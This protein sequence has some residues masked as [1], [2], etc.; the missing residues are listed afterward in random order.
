MDRSLAPSLSN[1]FLS[2]DNSRDSILR[3]LDFSQCDFG[4]SRAINIL[5][6]SNIS[7]KM[8]HFKN[9]KANSNNLVH[10]SLSKDLVFENVTVK[11]ISN[12]SPAM[13]ALFNVF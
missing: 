6:S 5:Q 10:I 1:S 4:L 2:L 11:N 13:I 3:T 9:S 8:L 7:I 12:D